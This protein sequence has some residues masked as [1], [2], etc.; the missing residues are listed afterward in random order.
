MIL[1][2][3]IMCWIW[4]HFIRS[5]EVYVVKKNNLPRVMIIGK[6]KKIILYLGKNSLDSASFHK[7]QHFYAFFCSLC[8]MY[9]RKEFQRLHITCEVVH[10]WCYV[11]GNIYWK[12]IKNMPCICSRLKIKKKITEA[13]PYEEKKCLGR[14]VYSIWS[15]QLQ[16]IQDPTPLDSVILVKAV[17]AD[18]PLSLCKIASCKK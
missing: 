16:I 10:F 14:S 8:R 3:I 4:H 9:K 11:K 15:I 6:K 18:C 17:A 1:Y 5:L 2:E 13:F 7:I 12:N